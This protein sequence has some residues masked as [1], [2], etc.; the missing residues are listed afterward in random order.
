MWQNLGLS[1]KYLSS[2]FLSICRL[3]PPALDVQSHVEESES[4]SL[5]V[6]VRHLGGLDFRICFISRG[7]GNVTEKTVQ[8]KSDKVSWYSQSISRLGEI[9]F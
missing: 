8:G 4:H 2:E 7:T 1:Q 5:N 9:E 3:V 6:P